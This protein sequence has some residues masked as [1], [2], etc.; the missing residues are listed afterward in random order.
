MTRCARPGSSSARRLQAAGERVFKDYNPATP[1]QRA[2]GF[3]FLTQNLGQAFDLALETKDTR[4]PVIHAFCTPLLQARRRR[5][6]LHLSAGLDR[7]AVAST[8]S[9]ATGAPRDSS[10]S[11]CRGRARRRCPGPTA[12]SLH[13]PF[14]DIPEANLFGHQLE[15]AWDGSFELYLGGPR[16]GPN[17]LP[18]TPGSRKLFIRQGFDRWN[19]TARAPVASS[20]S[21]WTSRARCRRPKTIVGAIDWAGRFVTR[22]DERLARSPLSLQQRRRPTRPGQRVPA[23]RSGG[24]RRRPTSGAAARPRTCAGSSGPTRR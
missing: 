14:G 18:T 17:W 21:A 3:R 10:T 6:R 5:S 23:G 22:P 4:Y 15:T 11:P 1:L 12:P 8:R 20:A 9:R 7:R 16:R 19:E 13:E 24:R 2:D